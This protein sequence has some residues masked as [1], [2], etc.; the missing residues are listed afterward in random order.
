MY[1]PWQQR[2][3]Q[4]LQQAE[5][6]QRLHHALLLSGSQGMGK[7]DFAREMAA[8]RLC[9]SPTEQAC[10]QC[11]SCTLLKASSHP[12]YF[13]CQPE[14]KSRVI[15][16]DQI[17]QLIEKLSNTSQR[18]SGQVVVIHPAEAMNIAAANA[19]LKTLEEPNGEVLLILVAHSRL[20]IPATIISRCQPVNFV[21]DNEQQALEWLTDQVEQKS[22][23]ELAWRLSSGAPLLALE[24]LRSDR[25]DWRNQMLDHMG[26]IYQS[27]QD[28]IADVSALCKLDMVVL[29]NLM[30][31]IV[32][33][34]V[35]LIQGVTTEYL[36]HQDQ[37]AKL[38]YLAKR[39]PLVNLLSFQQELSQ[40]QRLWLSSQSINPQLLLEYV[41][42]K[43][44]EVKAC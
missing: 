2:Q 5:Q 38:N 29:L 28:P 30:T 22:N 18:S 37:L 40:R 19:L 25:I 7:L 26:L 42:L 12:D 11:R 44:S 1:Y 32:N 27:Q 8:L 31:S 4:Q 36:V 41:L 23:L 33:D 43:W 10:G 24:Y 35:G 3:W 15:K 34:L 17:R 20:T 6:Q 13:E 16:V 9:E 21:V 39:L 14:E